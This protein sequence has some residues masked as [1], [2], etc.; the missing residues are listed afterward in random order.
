MLPPVEVTPPLSKAFRYSRATDLRCSSVMTSC[1]SAISLPSCSRGELL[2]HG[3]GPKRLSRERREP[4]GPLLGPLLHG[5]QA[6][7][8]VLAVRGERVPG[9]VTVHDLS[10]AQLGEPVG[11]HAGRQPPAAGLQ[12]AE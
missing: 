2:Q 7:E 4:R 1:D 10:L 3:I 8:Q 5:E 11:Q 9:V 12:V 6:L